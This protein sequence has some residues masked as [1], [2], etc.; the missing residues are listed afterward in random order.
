MLNDVTAALAA[1]EAEGEFATELACAP[2]DLHIEV[3]GAGPIH[4]PI[5]V[6]AARK[7]CAV[8]R[9]APYGRRDE[10]VYDARVRDTWEIDRSLLK[11]DARTWSRALEPKLEIVRQRLGLPEGGTL[12]AALD[13]MLVYGPGQFFASHQDSE[14][15]D[16]MVGSLVVELPSRHEGGAVV[17]QHH[18]EKK[19]LRGA[20]RGPK[21]LSLLA[22]YA[23]CHHEVTPV[24]AGYRITL[25]YHLLYRGAA[26]DPVPL[27]LP[28]IERLSA[29][30]RAYFATPVTLPYATSAPQRPDRFIYLLDHEYTQKSL[31]WSRLKGADRLRVSALRQVAERLDCEVHLALADVHESWSCE[32]DDLDVGYGRRASGRRDDESDEAREAGDHELVDLLDTDIELRHW[33]D[34][35]GRLAPGLHAHP[36]LHEVCFTRAS[37]EMAPFK[38]EHEGYMGNYGN[39]VDRWYHRAALVMWPRDRSFVVRAKVS[40]SWAVNELGARIEAGALDEARDRANELLPFWRRAASMETSQAFVLRLL[41]ITASL[42]DADLALG[43]LSPLGAH[44]LSPGTTAAFVA[45]V[46]RHGLSWSQRLFSAWDEDKRYDAPPWLS[47]LP[48]LCEALSAAGEHGKALAA[49]LLS[50]EVASFKTGYIGVFRLPDTSREEGFHGRIDDILSLLEAAAVTRAPSTRDDLVAFLTAP[51]TALPL[52]TAGALLERCREARTP[53]AVRA[54]G[55]Q[56]LVLRVMRLLERAL[57]AKPRS[58]DD[59]SIEPPHGCTCALCNELSAFLRD[60]DRVEHAWPLA[61]E[62]RRHI[63]SV[64]DLHRL[65]VTHTTIRAGRPQTLVL[66]KQQ[67]LFERDAALR[68]RQK[69]LSAWLKKQ[70]SAFTDAARPR[71]DARDA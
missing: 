5:S 60:R 32:E 29:S 52:M 62:R 22:F 48:H 70:W 18:R 33:V 57:A 36:A 31:G 20:A 40:P 19:V 66:T 17:V 30:V 49:W 11:I 25:T 46:Q 69:A 63:H 7:L 67:A 55:L 59:W 14:R 34:L 41:D 50:R 6:A 9:P 37:T 27:R 54:L 35:D 44:R 39:T 51:E 56:P 65:P 13:K 23:D 42:D 71:S 1:I 45:L 21:D 58:A 47:Y 16:D 43:L 8:A 24:E 4:F 61:K 26:V 53:A 28:A 12:E 3:E 38:S 10:T 2:G 15:D 68:A 64:I